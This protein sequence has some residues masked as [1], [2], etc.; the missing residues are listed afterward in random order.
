MFPFLC[1][2]LIVPSGEVALLQVGE[3]RGGKRWFQVLQ[4]GAGACET[5]KL[6]PAHSVTVGQRR[7]S[8][9]FSA[10]GSW[11]NVKPFKRFGQSDI[12]RQ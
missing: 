2:R 9:Y 7:M 10:G 4:L 1:A 11:Q 6:R 3:Y 5:L 8:C 12:V